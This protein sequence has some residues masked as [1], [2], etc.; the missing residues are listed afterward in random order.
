MFFKTRGTEA[1]SSQVNSLLKEVAFWLQRKKLRMQKK[2]E[3]AAL[4]E[5]VCT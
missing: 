2:R 3:T 4:E 1:N 5:M